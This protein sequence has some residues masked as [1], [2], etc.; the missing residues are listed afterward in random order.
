MAI[1]DTGLP[2]NHPHFKRISERTDW[3]NEKTLDDGVCVCVC[4][5]N[6]CAYVCMCVWGMYVHMYVC[7]WYICLYMCVHAFVCRICMCSV[8]NKEQMMDGQ[9]S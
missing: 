3:T 1:F 7:V 2:K 9:M 8:R 6:V 5:C 4:V